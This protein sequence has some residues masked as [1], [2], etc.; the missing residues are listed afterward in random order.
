MNVRIG[1]LNYRF[2][3]TS[4]QLHLN[5]RPVKALVDHSMQTVTINNTR[6]ST[7]ACMCVFEDAMLRVLRYRMNE[8]Y[9]FLENRS[10]DDR[11]AA[12][13]ETSETIDRTEP[14]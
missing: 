11:V 1:N 3:T 13:T 14:Q 5:G 4:E 7:A 8:V 9:T 12:L 10:E 6:S 2:Q